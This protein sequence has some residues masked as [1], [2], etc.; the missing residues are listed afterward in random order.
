MHHPAMRQLILFVRY[1]K[2]RIS[3]GVQAQQH[4]QRKTASR[5][6]H[7]QK[8][9]N[10]LLRHSADAIQCRNHQ[11]VEQERCFEKQIASHIPAGN[12][13]PASRPVFRLL[14]KS[15][16]PDQQPIEENTS[17]YSIGK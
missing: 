7:H 10:D 12:G 16:I 8:T 15:E 14:K 4:H 1:R 3:I 6:Q 5:E 2:L 9:F 11:Q 17:G 13:L